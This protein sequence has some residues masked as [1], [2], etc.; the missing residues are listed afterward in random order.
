MPKSN[1]HPVPAPSVDVICRDRDRCHD[2][3]LTTPPRVRLTSSAATAT[4]VIRRAFCHVIRRDRDRCR[5]RP[6]SRNSINHLLTLR[7]I[8][9]VLKLVWR[10]LIGSGGG[11]FFGVSWMYAGGAS[12]A[13]TGNRGKSLAGGGFG[14]SFGSGGGAFFGAGLTAG[15]GLKPAG[16]GC[17]SLAGGGP[18][19]FGCQLRTPFLVAIV[20]ARAG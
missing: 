16:R 10:W 1:A 12:T 4:A 13:A 6:L 9:D 15:G 17:R 7:G 11:A 8:L 2:S 14:T 19:C 3:M 5:P 20:I 18:G